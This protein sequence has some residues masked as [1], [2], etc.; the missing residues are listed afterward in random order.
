MD[1]RTYWQHNT[2]MST[3]IGWAPTLI[4]LIHSETGS[5]RMRRRW[6]RWSTQA[7]LA[8]ASA[9]ATWRSHSCPVTRGS[10]CHVKAAE[11][12]DSGAAV[13]TIGDV[14]T[15][16]G[17]TVDRRRVELIGVGTGTLPSSACVSARVR[18]SGRETWRKKKA[19]YDFLTYIY[20]VHDEI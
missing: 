3:T 10:S 7:Y 19:A 4:D 16:D 8:A 11:I 1:G 13:L 9:W 18:A 2:H 6:W 15:V 17:G 20:S 12:G 5:A 14:T